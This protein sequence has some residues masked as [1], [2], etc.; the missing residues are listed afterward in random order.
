MDKTVTD[1]APVAAE[2]VE[3]VD[4]VSGES[5]EKDPVTLARS[6][7]GWDTTTAMKRRLFPPAEAAELPLTVRHRILDS[8]THMGADAAVRS[9]DTA[10][11]FLKSLIAPRFLPISVTLAA[12]VVGRLVLYVPVANGGAK[13]DRNST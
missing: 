10:G 8:D 6:S 13:I 7:K 1:T 12:P 2:L 4:D 11:E 3:T 5:T 9:K